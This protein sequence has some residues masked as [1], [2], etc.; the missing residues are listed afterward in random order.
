MGSVER[1]QPRKGQ[2]GALPPWS[3]PPDNVVPGAVALQAVAAASSKAVV[4]VSILWA[5]PVGFWYGLS[6]RLREPQPHGIPEIGPFFE[7]H[8]RDLESGAPLYGAGEQF[9]FTLAFADGRTP[10]FTG[11]VTAPSPVDPEPDGGISHREL[12]GG[13]TPQRSYSIQ[14]VWPLPPPG[15]LSF[16]CSWPA[17]AIGDTC[18]EMDSGPIREAAARA[19]VLWPPGPG[20]GFDTGQVPQPGQ[21]GAPPPTAGAVHPMWR[22]RSRSTGERTPRAFSGGATGTSG[23]RPYS[24]GA[25]DAGYG[26]GGG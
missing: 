20:Y 24:G 6:I 15:P 17:M 23:P 5:C 19:I 8:G 26:R 12:C 25:S 7:P 14:W 18:V 16:R 21:P 13:V 10:R 9:H 4:V 11:L 1:R 22:R 3:A 2:G